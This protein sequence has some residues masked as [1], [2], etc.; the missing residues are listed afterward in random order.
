MLYSF[1][2]QIQMNIVVLFT[3]YDMS[4]H[5]VSASSYKYMA[6]KG[7]HSDPVA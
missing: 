3:I 6:N 2:I 1:S 4:Y 5:K 7:Y